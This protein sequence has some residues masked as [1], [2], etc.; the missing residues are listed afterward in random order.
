MKSEK[1]GVGKSFSSSHAQEAK[2]TGWKFN[3]LQHVLPGAALMGLFALMTY[4]FV[5]ELL[6]K[7]WP[8]Y[9]IVGSIMLMRS[10]EP[11]N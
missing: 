5:P 6:A 7:A 4:Q 1:I 2:K 11:K 3:H 10:L 9:L 8:A